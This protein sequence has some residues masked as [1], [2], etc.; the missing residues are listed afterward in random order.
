MTV[1]SWIYR[2]FRLLRQGIL[3]VD[4]CR[5]SKGIVW[6]AV[7][8]RSIE[9]FSR[10]RQYLKSPIV[11]GGCGRSGT[12]LLLSLLSTQPN[13]LAIPGETYSLCCGRKHHIG[14]K[15]YKCNKKVYVDQFLKFAKREGKKY[16]GA[17]VVEKTPSNV[18]CYGKILDYLG[19]N[20]SVLNIVRD[21]RDVV[22]S[23][24][25][26]SEKEYYI[27]PERWINDVK[28]G[29]LF[30]EKSEV[31]TIRYENLVRK[32]KQT[33]K[34]ISDHCEFDYKHE[35]V[36]NYPHA[37]RIKEDP[38]WKGKAR[39]ISDKSIGRWKEERYRGRVRELMK[40]E[41]AVQL[42]EAYNY[43]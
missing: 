24:H 40:K 9:E 36:V 17:R 13:L 6:C 3:S 37:A 26:E 33:I 10:L 43:V 31:L 11:I 38:A 42:L 41:K 18:L 30:E 1:E 22:T 21:G 27:D 15:K 35:K 12:T 25:P 8:S 7:N 5:A 14:K 29:R 16:D 19:G 39:E 32:T 28:K 4:R 20:V 34:K 23:S 2:G